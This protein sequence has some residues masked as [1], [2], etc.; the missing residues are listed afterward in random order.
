MQDNWLQSRS[1]W[2]CCDR[3]IQ[4]RHFFIIVKLTNRAKDFLNFRQVHKVLTDF[5]SLQVQ[6]FRRLQ[7][8]V[9]RYQ[10]PNWWCEHDSK[11]YGEVFKVYSFHVSDL[12]PHGPNQG[13]DMFF[14]HSKK[15]L[16]GINS[17]QSRAKGRCVSRK[18]FASGRTA[19]GHLRTRGGRRSCMTK[20][21]K[22]ITLD[23]FSKMRVQMLSTENSRF[24]IQGRRY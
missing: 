17:V 6:R 24:L 16:D 7:R 22:F 20:H 8:N 15:D 2:I 13:L 1:I 19:A 10:T 9:R 14:H 11:F 23:V 3:D 21:S 4:R 18:L 5:S 12:G